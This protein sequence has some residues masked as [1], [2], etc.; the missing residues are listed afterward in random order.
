MRVVLIGLAVIL[1]GAVAPAVRAG[2]AGDYRFAV[3][4][5]VGYRLGGDF[6]ADDPS[7]AEVSLNDAASFG[8]VINVPAESIAGDAYT[9][10][11][12]YVSRQSAGVDQAPAGVDPA[13]DLDI[14]HLLVGGTYVGAGEVMRPF[15]AAG[16]GA[17]HLSPGASGYESD[18]VFA[19][20]LGVGGQFFADRRVGLRLEGRVLGAVIDSDSAMFC[21]SGSEG[22]ACAFRAS[23]DVLWQWEVFAGL[24]ARF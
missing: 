21:A 23:G 12:V 1:S 10:W 4:P 7:E 8:L 2:E 17:A 18:T 9:E 3:T 11:E 19:F 16:I 20:G 15:L 13:I 24:T 5:F 22:S 14:T 6:E